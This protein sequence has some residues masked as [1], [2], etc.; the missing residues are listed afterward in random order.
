VAQWLFLLR[1]IQN[2]SPAF[3]VTTHTNLRKF[4]G[5]TTTR[6][7]ALTNLPQFCGTTTSR[8]TA[9]TNLLQFCG[10]TTSRVTALTNV[11]QFCG[12]T[13]SRVTALTNLLQFCGTTLTN[14]LQFCGTTTSRVT[15]LTNVPQFCGTTTSCVTALTNLPQF[16]GTAT[17]RVTTHTT[18]QE[19]W[20]VLHSQVLGVL[21]RRFNGCV[22]S[23]FE[24][25]RRMAPSIYADTWHQD[26][27]RHVDAPGRLIIWRP[28]KP[29]FFKVFRS[30]T[31]W[32]GFLKRRI[33]IADNFLRN[34]L[35][36][37][38]L[39]LPAPHFRLF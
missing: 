21:R 1:H 12:T 19:M 36:C 11:P 9:L 31:D 20:Y 27:P 23:C 7:T 39:S 3:R 34:S 6:V 33:Q 17:F 2:Y 4:C 5:T 14:L 22:S 25:S 24:S 30:R 8:V 15:A 35:A 26:R 37:E 38:N 18:P 28:F 10:T 32:R 29:I 13:T 16:C